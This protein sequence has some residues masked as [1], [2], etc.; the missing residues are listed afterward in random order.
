MNRPIM[1]KKKT[2]L[3]GAVGL[4][5][6]L[7]AV[8]LF[9]IVPMQIQSF[10]SMEEYS[11]EQLSQR[12]EVITK[13]TIVDAKSNIHA[14][15][16]NPDRPTVLTTYSVKPDTM[17]KG[18]DRSEVIEFKVSGG[19]VNNVVHLSDQPVFEKGELVLLFLSKE[20]GTIYDDDYYLTGVTQGV[21][22]LKDDIAEQEIPGRTTTESALIQRIQQE[23]S[24]N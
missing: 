8:M 7:Q 15:I 2:A 19:V 24:E 11:V 18:D 12:A 1:T 13:G 17:I 16:T 6:L 14:S 5:A 9:G 4:F 22:K 3:F 23:L 21:Y 20:A 10:T